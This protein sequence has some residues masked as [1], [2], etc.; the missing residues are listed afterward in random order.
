MIGD[1]L[2]KILRETSVTVPIVFG[3]AAHADANSNN[4]NLLN[5]NNTD[6]VDSNI[7]NSLGSFDV[8]L[9]ATALKEYNESC[10]WAKY[11]SIVSD[12]RTVCPINSLAENF[13]KLYSDSFVSFYVAKE[14]NPDNSNESGHVADSTTDISAIFELFEDQTFGSNLRRKFYQF[15][16]GYINKLS[17]EIIVFDKKV[18]K[19]S[20]AK[21]RIWQNGE[22][23]LV[24][25]YGRKF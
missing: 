5:W 23:S 25:Q 24:P 20:D 14:D 22:N 12:I 15:A 17:P 4:Y 13:T 21:C 7:E 3:A 11:I 18:T 6:S 9:S 19:F 2:D 1:S 8:S 10:N 16:K